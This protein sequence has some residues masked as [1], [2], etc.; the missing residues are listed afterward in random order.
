VWDERDEPTRRM[1]PP[2]PPANPGWAEDPPPAT[3]PTIPP[4]R[5]ANLDQTRAP[6]N[7]DGRTALAVPTHQA[8]KPSQAPMIITGDGH[9]ARPR[10]LLRR[11]QPRSR[12]MRAALAS[13]AACI[14]LAVLFAATPIT[15]GATGQ[16]TNFL[17][18]G[19]AARLPTATPTATP[20]LDPNAGGGPGSGYNPGPA[21]IIAEIKAVFGPYSVGALAVAH[22]ESGY[23]PNAW[24]RISILGS[25]AEGVFQIL[26]PSTWNNTAYASYSPYNAWANIHAAHDIFARDGNT[27]REWECQP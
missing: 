7:R 6:A 8:R 9:A 13:F 11:T 22:C 26:Y 19:S 4:I 18:G 16:V 21:A 5:S 2:E 23:D 3:L 20:T 27:W 25:H 10:P 17:A 1:P 15:A 12:A 24:N 14:V